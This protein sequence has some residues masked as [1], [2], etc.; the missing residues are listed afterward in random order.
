M[1]TCGHRVMQPSCPFCLRDDN[2][3]LRAEIDKLKTAEVEWREAIIKARE[4]RDVADLQIDELKRRLYYFN[5]E[6]D[7]W[8]CSSCGK[9][10]GSREFE[11]IK[12]THDDLCC[13]VQY[14]DKPKCEECKG[15]GEIGLADGEIFCPKCHPEY[16]KLKCGCPGTDSRSHLT[17]CAKRTAGVDDGI[18]EKRK[19]DCSSK[20]G[21]ATAHLIGCPLEKEGS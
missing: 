15:T 3:S 1:T 20:T 8:Y 19:C 4:A 2:A 10:Q 14:T 11:G 5:I 21:Y 9:G 7:N 12:N 17:T 6:H 16:Y 18:A 13:R